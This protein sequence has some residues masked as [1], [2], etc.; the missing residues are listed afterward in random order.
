MQRIFTI[1]LRRGRLTIRLLQQHTQLSP[2]Q[3]RHG[4]AVLIQQNLI[5][6]LYEEDTKETL[7]EAN[8]AAAYALIRCG[9]FIEIAEAKFGSAGQSLVRKLLLLGQATVSDLIDACQSGSQQE[10]GESDEINVANGTNGNSY[11]GHA[12]WE[13]E[14]TLFELCEAGFLEAINSRMFRSPTDTRNGIEKALLKETYGGSIKGTKQKGELEAAVREKLQDLRDE[15]MEWK[16]KGRKRA[17]TG[18]LGGI[19]SNGKRQK[20]SNGNHNQGY[21]GLRLEVGFLSS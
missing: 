13:L 2:R 1:L 18:D 14:N 11:H 16:S 6:Y 3:L 10:H 19:N 7:Y 8:Q 9:K 4:L 5:Y 20:L 15:D 21:E 12:A 17:H